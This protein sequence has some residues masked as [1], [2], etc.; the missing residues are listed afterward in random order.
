MRENEDWGCQALKKK[1]TM[2]PHI[3]KCSRA[4]V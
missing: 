2:E 3:Y 1:D 4:D